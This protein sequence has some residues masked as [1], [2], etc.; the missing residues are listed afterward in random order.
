ME[1]ASLTSKQNTQTTKPKLTS[2]HGFV[3][4][5][6]MLKL[7]GKESMKA[8]KLIPHLPCPLPLCV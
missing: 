8:I 1:S 3:L 4:A 2:V 5:L 6:F 7:L